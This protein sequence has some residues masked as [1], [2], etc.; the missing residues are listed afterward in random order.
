[1]NLNN[2]SLVRKD[3]LV[4]RS[5]AQGIQLMDDFKG[6]EQQTQLF[7][8]PSIL[9]WPAHSDQLFPLPLLLQ[10]EYDKIWIFSYKV[11]NV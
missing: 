5:S 11:F 3:I 7:Q 2:I 6:K 1:M 9:T 4:E 8:A 10:P